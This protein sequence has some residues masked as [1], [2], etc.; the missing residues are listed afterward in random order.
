M[1]SVSNQ[2]SGIRLTQAYPSLANL[3]RLV[4][5]LARLRAI[6]S[7]A[8][9]ALPGAAAALEVRGSVTTDVVWRRTDSPVNVTAMVMVERGVTLQI[10]PGVTVSLARDA[11]IIVYG[12]L[13]ARGTAADSIRFTAAAGQEPG[14]WGGVFLRGSDAPASYDATSLAYAGAGSILEYCVIEF[15]GNPDVEGGA[16]LGVKSSAP[17]IAHSVVRH[18]LGTTGAVR[19]LNSAAPLFLDC[20]FEGNRAA[21]GGAMSSGV[22]SKPLLRGCVL[23][24]N[25]ASDNG[26][27]LYV[28]LADADLNGNIICGNSAGSN[29]G[30]V[31][32]A[33]V[34]NLSLIDNVF[35]DNHAQGGSNT[36]FLTERVSCRAIGNSFDGIGVVIYLQKAELGVE[37]GGN[38]WGRAPTTI[39]FRD[40]IRDRQSDRA[41]PLVNYDPP[42]WAPVASTPVVPRSIAKIIFCRT[43]AYTTQIPRGV[44]EGAPLRIRLD[45]QDANPAYADVIPARVVSA[46]DPQGIAL[47]LSETAPASGIYTGRAVVAARSDQES[48]AI[49]DR[50]GGAVSVFCPAHP[51][52][53]ASYK[54]LTPRPVAEGIAVAGAADV[55]HI[56]VHQPTFTWTYYEP[57]DRPQRSLKI[58]VQRSSDGATAWSSG[59]VSSGEPQ[60]AYAGGALEDG[61]AY[62]L[63][64]TV[65]SGR[66]WSD[67]ATLG[68][69]MNSLPTAPEPLRP[70]ADALVPTLSPQ[71]AAGVAADRE[72][73]TLTYGFQL[74][75]LSGRTTT[76]EAS[77]LKGT[78]E[79]VWTAPNS[80]TENGAYRFRARAADPFEPGPWGEYRV[81]YV[82][83]IEEPPTAFEPLAPDGGDV[84]DLFPTLSWRPALDPDPLSSVVYTVEIA[85][86]GN[87]L[88]AHRYEGLTATQFQLPDSLE[89]RAE[90]SWR[91][92]ATDNTGR[93]TPIARAGKFRVETTPSTPEAAAPLAAE[94][95]KPGA[96]LSWHPSSDPD[97][98]DIVTYEI[99]VIATAGQLTPPPS[100][101]ASGGEKRGVQGK[102]LAWA[103]GWR[104]VE[105]PVGSLEG[106][107][108]LADNHVYQWRV[109]AR[110]THNAVSE[111][112]RLGSFF[113]NRYNDAPTAPAAVTAPGDSVRGTTAVTFGWKAGSDPDLSDGPA[114]LIYEVECAVG[115]FE[116]GDTRRFKVESGATELT[117]ALGDNRI[118]QYRVR[119]LDDE[120][121]ES[122]WTP[123]RKVLVNVAEDP[124]A[125]FSLVQ[126]TDGQ[127][128]AELDSLEL[129]WSASSDPDWASSLRY[130]LELTGAD[131]KS[132]RL[133]TAATAFLNKGKLANE[134]TY[135]WKVTAIDN[136]GRE[137][138]CN[139]EFAFRTNTTPTA[140]TATDIPAELLPNGRLTFGAASDPN[141]LDRL[142]YTVEIAADADFSP[143]LARREGIAH[144]PGVM[145][146]AVNELLGWEKLTDDRDYAYRARA[147]DN[148]RFSGPWGP[149]TRFR[150]NLA[151]DAPTPAAGPFEPTG[152]VTISD[153]SP[154]LKW[155]A[156]SDEDLSD[157][158]SSL[159]YEVRLDADGE[160]AK[161][162]LYEFSTPPGVGPEFRLPL[163]L[164]D[165]TPWVW[166]VR[167]KDDGGAFSAWSSVQSF[168][169]NVQ[170]DSPT[171][172]TPIR[173]YNG[174]SLNVLGPV[175]FGW[176]RSQDPDYRSSVA[177]RLTYGTVA[178]LTGGKTTADLKD[179]SCTIVG[180][181]ENTTYYWR[182]TAVDNTGRETNSMP[183]SVLLDTRPTV[184]QPALPAGGVELRPDGRFAWSGSADPN[185]A[186]QIGYTLTIA[187]EAGFD[188]PATEAKGLRETTIMV[189]NLPGK[190]KLAD[191]SR[192]YW[193]V[194]ATDNHGIESAWSSAAE[195]TF[196]EKNDPPTAFELTAP[197]SGDSLPAGDVKLR[198]GTAFDP[199]P[200]SRVSYNLMVARDARFTDRVQR[201]SG[202]AGSEFGLPSV[203]IEAGA[204]Y[205]WKVSAEDGLG[206]VTFGSGSDRTPWS[207][208][209]QMPPPPPPPEAPAP[210]PPGGAPGG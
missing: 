74:E 29:G 98:R 99:E 32:A 86:G 136:T 133:E 151:N 195:F 102:P 206:G 114:T 158:A 63:R 82:N 201:F 27:A 84:Y 203:L 171:P 8:A 156:S 208:R 147:T 134:A 190:G 121:A 73:D 209:I 205:Y 60:V 28:S 186:D 65:N 144:N 139:A 50:E 120:G 51:D 3:G 132:N 47:A 105:V 12:T 124:P 138:V 198:W 178:D 71:L 109:R 85:K 16:A 56:I 59:E 93:K 162:A 52:I 72:G 48:F 202:L 199:D 193:R 185:P 62:E 160:L 179:S 125:P 54:T 123:Q 95:R 55:T 207:F 39:N 146:A 141:P 18:C 96:A 200:A 148:H 145:S 30:A 164:A 126:P 19:C 88:A 150:F 91:V 6:L 149:A 87:W 188:A 90:Y 2:Q 177:Y 140:P 61:E 137:T 197:A 165:N 15:G 34:S 26:G 79:V 22:G 113:F 14:S 43:D 173:P 187:A 107:E 89:N 92:T 41:E 10:E 108:N 5:S 46:L 23:I 143:V 100:P 174:Q 94:E 40:A 31:F 130:R 122:P 176:T 131:G 135:R 119:T 97:P 69:R 104:G 184:P 66:L 142:T 4:M 9:L 68:F 167:A 38:Y 118:W 157:P 20:R 25:S 168:L 196:N 67:P 191:N 180:P 192:Y 7:V 37:A 194:K 76:P 172:P 36:L 129:R 127:A 81:F 115:S 33:R 80:L 182:V 166:A 117:A 155:G 175:T 111:F 204:V 77:G 49:G 101:P 159:V 183:A 70:L 83:S 45:G 153:R 64:L 42:L 1:Q 128:V 112:S 110:D 21:R 210:T 181:L 44:A 169:L 57:V 116:S 13:I 11:G 170:E 24:G 161:S 189:A 103:N 152:G 106:W 75:D 154:L 163:A 78:T 53:R 58:E 35:V 17:L